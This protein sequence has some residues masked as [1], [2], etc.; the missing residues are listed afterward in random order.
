MSL[1]TFFRILFTPGCWLRNDPVDYVL[2]RKIDHLLDTEEIIL[3]EH[4]QTKGASKGHPHY[5]TLGD[6]TLWSANYPYAFGSDYSK[7][8][9]VDCRNKGLPTREVCFRLYDRLVIEVD[10]DNRMKK[11]EK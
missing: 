2:S 10:R 5:I 11:G 1:K 6:M 8:Y 3:H 9:V 7:G 4:R